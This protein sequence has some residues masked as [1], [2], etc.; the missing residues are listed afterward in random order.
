MPNRYLILPQLCHLPENLVPLKQMAFNHFCLHSLLFEVFLSTQPGQI[1]LFFLHLLECPAM[2]GSRDKR[3]EAVAGIET[4]TLVLSWL[5]QPLGPRYGLAYNRLKIDRERSWVVSVGNYWL[6][7]FVADIDN[8]SSRCGWPENQIRAN[9]S[10]STNRDMSA[11]LEQKL[12]LVWAFN[13]FLY[14]HFKE[15]GV[16]SWWRGSGFDSSWPS[17]FVPCNVPI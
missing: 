8:D 4:R 10:S 5:R 11:L 13:I 2:T 15:C 9:R 17:N 6:D 16:R 12:T 7:S 14:W 3:S 1:M